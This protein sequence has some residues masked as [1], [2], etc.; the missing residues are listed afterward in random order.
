MT[1]AITKG[2]SVS[3]ET[4]FQ[5]EHSNEKMHQYVF[6]YRI[7]IENN[8]N[9]TVCLRRRHWHI[10]DGD[11]TKREV[12][13]EGVVGEQPILEP[14]SKYKYVSGCNISCEMGKMHG[15][16]TMENMDDHTFFD[17]DIPAFMME[18]PFILN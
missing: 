8:S 6:A 17:I 9:V 10:T 12:E 4:I 15:T 14:G 16:Y 18:V 3:V 2:I 13:G 11:G 7:L 5:R 1:I